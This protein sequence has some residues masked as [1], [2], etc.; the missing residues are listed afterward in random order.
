MGKKKLISRLGAVLIAFALVLS[1]CIVPAGTGV[2]HA[3]EPDTVL[4]DGNLPSDSE[5]GTS[6][7][8]S[9]GDND[10]VAQKGENLAEDASQKDAD[11]AN[12][13]ASDDVVS[14]ADSHN[15][16]LQSNDEDSEAIVPRSDDAEQKFEKRLLYGNSNLSDE[17]ALVL[18]FMA[19]GFTADEI[20]TFW[21]YAEESAKYT[22]TVSPWDEFTDTVKIYGIG[23]ISNQSGVKGDKAANYNE[24]LADSRDTYFGTSYWEGGSQRIMGISK[25]ENIAAIEKECGIEGSDSDIIFVNCKTEGG[26]TSFKDRRVILSIDPQVNDCTVHEL[27]HSIGQLADEYWDSTGERANKTQESD[28]AKVKWSRFVGLNGVGV[29]AYGTSGDQVKWFRPSQGCK[30]QLLKNDFCEVCKEALRDTIAESSN[31]TNI[32]FQTYADQFYEKEQGP[33]MS[34]YFILRKGSKKAT[35]DT[36]GDALHLTYKDSG[37][38]VVKGVPNKAGDYEVTA[39]FDGN[40]DFDKCT[41]TGSYT[42]QLPDLITINVS[43]KTYDGKPVEMSYKVDGYT[44]DQYDAKVTYTGTFPYSKNPVA[45][46]E[47]T[48]AP[49]LQG[50]YTVTVEI[51][52]KVTKKALAKK[53]AKFEIYFKMVPIIVNSDPDWPGSDSSNSNFTYYIYGDGYTADEEEKFIADATEY[54]K[55][56]LLQEPYRQMSSYFNFY[57]V[58][59][60]SKTSGI[61]NPDGDTYF[62]LSYDE[63]G[64]LTENL[65]ASNA[66]KNISYDKLDPYYRTAIIIT[67]DEKVTE[68]Y[69]I[70]DDKHGAVFAPANEKGAAYAATEAMSIFMRYITGNPDYVAT[71]DNIEEQKVQFLE[72]L[73]Y[74][75]YTMILTDAYNAKFVENGKP[76]DI[77]DYLHTYNQSKLI[78]NDM[79]EYEITYYADDNGKVGDELKGAPS[80]AGTY[81][82]FVALKS[83]YTSKWGDMVQ[84]DKFKTELEL[85]SDRVY[86][87]KAWTTFSISPSEPVRVEAVKPTYDKGGNVA[88]WSYRGKYY[89]DK[90]GVMD[91]STAYDDNSAFLLP[92]LEKDPN[93]GIND[94]TN[95]GNG[96]NTGKNS[97][98]GKHTNTGNYTKTNTTRSSVKTGDNSEIAM[99]LILLIGCGVIAT[100]MV[101][102]RRRAVK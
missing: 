43:S 79:I 82:A 83:N 11:S 22:M 50:N 58:P 3:K 20:D 80:E 25:P 84:N 28:P 32:D 4:N 21:K 15:I 13:T 61:S 24:A 41:M 81:H 34:Q 91:E 18:V 64:K 97:N 63:N 92:A 10:D 94:D 69:S 5:K 17:D 56:F 37:G 71:P 7:D 66:A 70:S 33:D 101:Y 57:A 62:G 46:S 38:N 74:S 48:E 23:T 26:S 95:T 45:T 36:L 86:V 96:T 65:A 27:G 29:Y 35:G 53:S 98:T 88:Y 75:S 68:G 54:A 40:N 52:D 44:E 93:A 51:S 6:E 100:V 42:I 16:N 72:W 49:T 78:P 85:S 59:T 67:D 89:A 9:E 1:M 47:S 31:V 30:M 60:V 99:W 39:V 76:V 19:D 90:N 55:N 8:S 102:M 73:A 12:D 2:V 77:R 87:T 14:N